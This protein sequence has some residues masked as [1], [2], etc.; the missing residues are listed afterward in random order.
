VD[1]VTEATMLDALMVLLTLV[2]FGIALAYI[3]GCERLE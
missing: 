2:F 1:L 3:V